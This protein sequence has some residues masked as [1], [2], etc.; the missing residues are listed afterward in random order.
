MRWKYLKYGHGGFKN[1]YLRDRVNT[2]IVIISRY[3]S[4]TVAYRVINNCFISILTSDILEERN[5]RVC[6]AL[7]RWR[8][9]VIILL[10]HGPF[11]ILKYILYVTEQYYIPSRAYLPTHIMYINIPTYT[12]Y[13]IYNKALFEICIQ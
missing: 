10:V 1:S 11:F 2:C 4:K 13:N 9:Y 3:R 5:G 8:L 6:A 7:R 12:V